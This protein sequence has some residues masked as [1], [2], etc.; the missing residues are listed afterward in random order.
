MEGGIVLNRVTIVFSTD[1][2]SF[3]RGGLAL[4]LLTTRH[5]KLCAISRVFP[6]QFSQDSVSAALL[7]SYYQNIGG[8]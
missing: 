6:P 7:P 8:L 5:T 1:I 2:A 3:A 4:G